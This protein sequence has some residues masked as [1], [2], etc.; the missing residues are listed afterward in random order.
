MNK[1]LLLILVL[2][3]IS[4]SANAQT[5]LYFRN[6]GVDDGLGSN[7][8]STFEDSNGFIWIGTLDG[9]VRFDSFSF[10][11][12]R[13]QDD[14]S[15]TIPSNPVPFILEGPTG[16]IW[17]GTRGGVGIIDPVSLNVT[18]RYAFEGTETL[19]YLVRADSLILMQ[20]DFGL[21]AINEQANLLH[22]RE[23]KGEEVPYLLSETRAI[24]KRGE[25]TYLIEYDWKQ[26]F[27][28][29]D[30]ALVEG[31]NNVV[32]RAAKW[33][34][35]STMFQLMEDGVLFERNFNLETGEVVSHQIADGLSN[36]NIYHL[37]FE[38]DG[39]FWLG[40]NP[41]LY[42]FQK[43]GEYDYI[44]TV[45]PAD[46]EASFGRKSVSFVNLFLDSA[47]RLWINDNSTGLSMLDTRQLAFKYINPTKSG[48][49][50]FK[51]DMVWNVNEGDVGELLL[52]TGDGAIQ[53][54][55]KSGANFQ[56][57]TFLRSSISESIV[58]KGGV[59]TTNIL[60]QSNKKYFSFFFDGIYEY[61][62]G[63]SEKL[64]PLGAFLAEKNKYSRN[65]THAVL[66]EQYILWGAYSGIIL[67]D[68]EHNTFTP[69]NLKPESGD[70]YPFDVYGIAPFMDADKNW[71]AY[72]STALGLLEYHYPD[73][74]YR[75]VIPDSIHIERTGTTAMVSKVI[76][77]K[78]W[79]GY[80]EKGIEIWDPES[81]N[82]EFVNEDT[83]LS[84]EGILGLVEDHKGRVWVSHSVGISCIEPDSSYKVTNFYLQD[85]LRNSEYAQNAYQQL[86]DNYLAFGGH[87]A[88]IFHPD[89][90]LKIKEIRPGFVFNKLKFNRVG[91]GVPETKFLIPGRK[92]SIDYKDN[93]FEVGFTE[94]GYSES[95]SV[96]YSYRIKGYQDD[97]TIS[98]PNV[99]TAFVNNISPGVYTLE[100]RTKR[101]TG[102]W[103]V[104]GLNLEIEVKPP[105][106][107]TRWFLSTMFFVGFSIIGFAAMKV[108]GLWYKRRIRRLE[109]DQRAMTERE[110]LSRD[111]HDSIGSQLSLIARH[112]EQ[113]QS[114]EEEESKTRLDAA[115]K[116]ARYT[117][118]QL[119][120]TLWALKNE[121]VY[122]SRM[123]E[124]LKELIS[125]MILGT[126]LKLVTHFH[127]SRDEKLQPIVILHLFRIVQEVTSNTIK[128]SQGTEITLTIDA[129]SSSKWSLNLTDN[130]LGFNL[131]E[132]DREEA[133][134]LNHIVHRAE[135]I[136]AF[137][138]LESTPG[139]GTSITLTFFR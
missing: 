138:Q 38:E 1:Q 36:T 52:G 49:P 76:N 35:D 45:I 17:A 123:A 88:V 129:V 117:I 2:W 100:V 110:Q 124:R 16:K 58:Y 39:S 130:G 111:L 14:D 31:S 68:T 29:T 26:G 105:F 82:M 134:G 27:T 22:H 10:E 5:G 139:N 63:K 70:F 72:L 50:Q 114:I 65:M 61:E 91:D 122:L 106:W 48:F 59:T 11:W 96:A 19:N 56:N 109:A 54:T 107:L 15:L 55:L 127:I 44:K 66:D 13:A 74:V 93:N 116:T 125:R 85:G 87:G 71:G 47:D 98:S 103:E 3:G 132:L 133:Y 94:Q 108:S 23:F 62:D 18:A 102:D 92:V 12:I 75:R 136:Q 46:K 86:S 99:R 9:L 77:G 24:Q 57:S 51:T 43:K 25:N 78:V 69:I 67:Q 120:E 81:G 83:G 97:W 90:V 112:L 28:F 30:S 95:E 121:E 104:P 7:T 113:V 118:S 137:A 20:S 8:F 115:N 64:F 53:Y 41:E 37:A 73:S 84:N 135:E 126:N 131:N 40:A 79:T 101:D 119:R 60:R 128:Y 89:T 21:Y 32:F 6:W 80:L 33:K 4:I 34:N 42:H